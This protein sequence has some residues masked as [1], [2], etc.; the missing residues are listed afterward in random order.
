M[1]AKALRPAR[2]E[3]VRRHMATEAEKT[4]AET[5]GTFRHARYEI[6]A[7]G[8]VHDGDDDVGDF[9][10]E[11]ATAFPDFHFENSVFHHTDDAVIVETDFVGTHLGMWR[12]LPATGRV[13]RYRMCNMF[14]FEGPDLVCERMYFDLLTVLRQLGIA[15]DPTT[16]SGRFLTLLNHPVTMAR[17][18][19][20]TLRSVKK[21][22][23][24]K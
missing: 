13:V 12:G 22:P 3:L 18:V 9:Y 24:A 4:F 5:L 8:E 16:L 7:T 11:S 15:R 2:E 14:L 1:D 19:W 17:A 6:V 10:R 23:S 21:P 20:P